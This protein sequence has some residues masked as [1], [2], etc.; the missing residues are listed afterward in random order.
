MNYLEN[1]FVNHKPK[2]KVTE[3]N[4]KKPQDLSSSPSVPS[5]AQD[6]RVNSAKEQEADVHQFAHY[7]T[8]NHA[9]Y[10]YNNADKMYKLDGEQITLLDNGVDGVQFVSN[11]QHEPF[12]FHPKLVQDGLFWRI[13]IHPLN[14][15]PLSAVPAQ[16]G[17]NQTSP[18]SG[19]HSSIWTS[20]FSKFSPITQKARFS[21]WLHS[22]PFC[23]LFPA[24]PIFVL[25]G[26]QGSG[27]TVA[28]QKIGRFLFG[29]QFH[30]EYI[31]REREEDFIDIVTNSVFAVFDNVDCNIP[32]LE[33]YL[34]SVA[35][36]EPIIHPKTSPPTKIF[37]S[38]CGCFIALNARKLPFAEF[39]PERCNILSLR[40]IT[41]EQLEGIAFQLLVIQLNRIKEPIPEEEIYQE[42]ADN[43]NALWSE[44]LL[45]PN[46]HVITFASDAEF[47]KLK[48]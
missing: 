11:P 5:Q 46:S 29:S 31:S 21:F 8:K 41:K 10:V 42:V 37:P 26:E 12:E 18:S 35:T 38:P 15:S 9:L 3:A 48:R 1:R 17:E 24:K 33:D 30:V 20:G 36:C 16:A 19:I 45:K 32:W 23:S 44:F 28:H 34:I 27:K 6:S 22:L 13:M 39:I 47:F 43:R 40:S 4:T 14:V 25:I 2:A 7:N